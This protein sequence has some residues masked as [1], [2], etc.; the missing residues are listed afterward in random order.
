MFNPIGMTVATVSDQMI[1]WSDSK[2]RQGIARPHPFGRR[3]G[4]GITAQLR[5]AKTIMDAPQTARLAR[6]LNRR[7]IHQAQ[8]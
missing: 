4:K 7:T 2:L 8:A 6:L 5:H 1:S 3:Q